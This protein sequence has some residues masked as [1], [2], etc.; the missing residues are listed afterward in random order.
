MTA[1]RSEE[2]WL[3]AGFDVFPVKTYLPLMMSWE[4]TFPGVAS[5][6]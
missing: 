3:A 6:R 4:E 1:D 2:T 5:L